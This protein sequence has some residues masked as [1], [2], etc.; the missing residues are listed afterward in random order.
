MIQVPH[1]I[2]LLVGL[3]QDPVFG[4]VITVGAGGEAVEVLAD[5]ALELP[6]LDDE[7]ARAMIARTRV[8]R[9]LAGYRHVPPA[10]IDAIVR[11]INAV[12]AIAV[13]LPDIE[14]LDINPLLVHPDGVVA[15][16]YRVRVAERPQPSR[17]AIRPVPN[18]WAGD[19]VTRSGVALHVRP[20]I[21]TDEDAL[22]ELFRH[23]SPEDM[24][25]RFLTGL[26]EVGRD[27]LVAMSQVDY[28]R[29]INF[30]AFAG[31]LLIA[32]A[33]LA[34]DPDL[35]RAELAVSVHR[36]WKGK[37]VSWTLVEHVLRYAR[38]EGISTVESIE[39]IDNHAALSLEQEMGFVPQ[40]GGEPGER[41]VRYNTQSARA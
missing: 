23:V 8:S 18:E 24:R 26:W 12:S 40:G 14:E 41:V 7:L 21:P 30:L 32:T 29:T 34:C 28:R 31:P 36:D 1:S 25:F 10:D 9:L 5:R 16:D 19:L 6:P 3:A 38:A 33:M 22:A 15:L 17:L 20:V 11:V 13:D 27:R 37:G 2:E 35:T 39:S 4:P